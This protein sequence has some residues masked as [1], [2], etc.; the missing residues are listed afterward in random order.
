VENEKVKRI[1]KLRIWYPNAVYHITSSKLSHF[2][3]SLCYPEIP[4]YILSTPENSI[5]LNMLRIEAF[6]QRNWKFNCKYMHN[7][8][9]F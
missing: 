9:I 5:H 4:H 6:S 8:A 7:N 2:I 3:P 1:R